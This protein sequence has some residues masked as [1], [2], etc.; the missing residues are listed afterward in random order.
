MVRHAKEKIL[1]ACAEIVALSNQFGMA[2]QNLTRRP[3]WMPQPDEDNKLILNQK[4][5]KRPRKR[6]CHPYDESERGQA[7]TRE[8]AGDATKN[9]VKKNLRDKK[10]RR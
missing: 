8:L 10:G 2:Q 1:V 5:L 9:D 4:F 3:G 6:I 7:T